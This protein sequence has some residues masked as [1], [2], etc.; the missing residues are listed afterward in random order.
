M[1]KRI[2]HKGLQRFHESGNTAGIN[3]A[4][5]RRI[6]MI[7]GLLEAA[8][9]PSQLDLQG[10]HLHLLK[11]ERSDVWSLRVNKYW[12]VTFKFDGDD[13]TDV[14]YEDYH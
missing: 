11:G 2:R 12:R 8:S 5:A 4:Q 9:E 14:N 3:V 7:L 10:L 6:A 13:V 1:I